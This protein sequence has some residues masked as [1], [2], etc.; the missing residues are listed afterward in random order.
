MNSPEKDWFSAFSKTKEYEKL[1]HHPVAYFCAEYALSSAL[2]TYAGG[3]GILAGDYVREVGAQ[4]FPMIS[5]GI[6]Y[7]RAQS[8]LVSEKEVD[9]EI[10]AEHKLTLLLDSKGQKVIISIPIGQR[11][12]KAIVWKWQEFNASVYLLDTN[13]S[14]NDERDKQITGDLYTDNRLERLR[15]EIL[16]GIG[17]YELI[18]ELEIMP[19]VYHLNEGHSAF[20]A[21]ALMAEGLKKVKNLEEAQQKAKQKIFYTNHTLVLEGQ[22]QFSPDAIREQLTKYAQKVNLPLDEVIQMGIEK[23]SNMFSMTTFAFKMSAKSN[24]VSAIHAVKAQ[25]LWPED[26]PTE[27]ITNGIYLPRWDQLFFDSDTNGL[28]NKHQENKRNLLKYIFEKAGVQW[29]ENILLFG[30]ARRFV[31]YK[32]PL[33]FLKNIERLKK[34]FDGSN[35]LLKIV[36]AGP[37][38]NDPKSNSIIEELENL[39][40]SHF[41]DH[42]V[43]LPN[44]N[45]DLAEIL[46]A[47]CDV[48]LNTPVIGREACGTSGMKAG[49]NGALPFSTRDGWIGEVDLRDCG[50]VI[51]E[52]DITEK[53]LN[54]TEEQIIPLYYKHFQDPTQSEWQKRMINSRNLILNRFSMSRVLRQ[55]IEKLYLPLLWNN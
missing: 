17:G 38:G 24:A 32:Q 36:Y 37:T 1:A 9:K 52:P 8:M 19:S 28:W 14:E 12:V 30:W 34:I 39:I 18:K 22:E 26:H 35:S 53:L 45:V 7:R 54:C 13:I 23:N 33:A 42:V 4:N 11:E 20:M 43:F 21:I 47:G 5:I 50:W 27:T 10:V 49:L 2:P 41:K 25:Q 3:L 46:V 48:W 31:E 29:D 15:Q 55:Y 40:E 6:L 16:L 44:Y 51:D